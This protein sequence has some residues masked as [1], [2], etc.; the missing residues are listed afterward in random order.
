MVLLPFLHGRKGRPEDPVPFRTFSS[1]ANFGMLSH[2]L[3]AVNHFFH[4]VSGASVRACRILCGFFTA[5]LATRCIIAPPSG[6][7][8]HEFVFFMSQN[9]AIRIHFSENLSQFI[10]WHILWY[11]RHFQTQYMVLFAA[12]HQ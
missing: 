5:V 1:H 4:P 3:S 10:F 11:F 9:L 8:K 12:L 2:H 6:V 7:C